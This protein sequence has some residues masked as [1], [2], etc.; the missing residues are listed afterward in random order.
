MRAKIEMTD[1]RGAL[2]QIIRQF[3]PESSHWNEAQNRFQFVDR[4]LVECLGWLQSDLVVEQ[5]DEGGGR[6]DY[7]LGKSPIKAVLEAKREAKLFD[8]ITTQSAAK[9]RKLGPL[10][11]A[12]KNFKD[13]VTQVIPYCALHG[14]PVAVVCNGPQL[15]IFQAITPGMPPLEGECYLF[16]GYQAYLDEFPLLW[17]LLSPEGIAENRAFR[18][19]A[20]HRNRRKRQRRSRN[21]IGIGIETVSEKNLGRCPQ[22]S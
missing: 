19:L 4:L 15:A 21:P 5:S 10:L 8:G 9:L 6:A 11:H 2:E 16:D 1:G 20:L 12:S 22:F 13:A 18:D 17:K 3:P 14:A 7:L